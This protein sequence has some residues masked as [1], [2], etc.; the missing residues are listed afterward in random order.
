MARPPGLSGQPPP[1]QVEPSVDALVSAAGSMKGKLAV[2]C[3]AIANDL[4]A[5]GV[6]DVGDGSNV[7]DDDLTA[8]CDKASA[9]ITA[10]ISASGSISVAIEG[11]K[12]EVSASAQFDCEA[13]CDVNGTC[14]PGSIEAQ[15]SPGELSGTC[16][17]ECK[18]GATCQ[19]SA[20]VAADCKGTCEAT[21]TGTCGGNCSGKCEGTC[22][23]QDGQGNCTGTC[24]G[25]CT[26]KCD[27]QCEGKCSGNCKLAA[28]ANISCGAEAT[29][30]GECSVA[31]TAPKCEAKLNPPSCNLDA[32][33]EAGCQGQA[34]AKVECSEPKI[35]V[36]GS[37]NVA[38]AA[39]LEANLP[40]VFAVLA[41]GKVVASAAGDVV[42]KVPDVVAAVAGSVS[43]VASFGA[44]FAADLQASAAASVSVNVSV[45]ASAKTS[46]SASGG[47]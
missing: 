32:N 8:T 41:Q 23:A 45:S 34:S 9:S 14:E 11:G 43:C 4:G 30:K 10:E 40:A 5:T 2:A 15:C 20:T 12:C 35:V 31:M 24:D 28:D 26:G 7:S 3:A 17:G 39:T 25:T 38:F 16:S 6:P 21:C 1:T 42:A 22:S 37:A 44:S 47:T 13:S 18:A 29:C 36:T 33:C 27:T 46:G 19:G